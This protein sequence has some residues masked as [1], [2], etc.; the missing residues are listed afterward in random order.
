MQEGKVIVCASGYFNPLHRGHISYLNEAKKLGDYLVVIVDNDFQVGLKGSKKFMDEQERCLI[1]SNLK[2]V[3]EVRLSID[4]DL[5]VCKSLELIKPDIFAKG[6][7]RTIDN[8]PEKEICEKLGIKMVF[9]VGED[10]VQ[11]SSNLLTNQENLT[12]C[13]ELLSSQG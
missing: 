5:S 10:K 2:C 7:D 6:G 11:S 1:I 12:I 8:I 4:T 13:V 9:G 3:D